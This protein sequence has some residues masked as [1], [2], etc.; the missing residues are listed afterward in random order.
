[1]F[2]LTILCLNDRLFV[3]HRFGVEHQYTNVVSSITRLYKRIQHLL[4]DAEGN[5]SANNNSENNNNNISK[6][7]T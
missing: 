4:S 5:T 7:L 1:M 2:L 6:P 3:E